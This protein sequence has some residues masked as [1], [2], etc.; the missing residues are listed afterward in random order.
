MDV[1]PP[2]PRPR[3]YYYTTYEI[4]LPYIFPSVRVQPELLVAEALSARKEGKP[5]ITC[6]FCERIRGWQGV[7]SF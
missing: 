4:Q 7:I 3:R 2:V 1:G 5:E 6:K